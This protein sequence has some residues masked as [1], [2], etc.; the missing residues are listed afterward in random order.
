[1]YELNEK[2]RDLEPYAS[3]EGQYKIRL[4][5]NESFLRLP[6]S[7]MASALHASLG[8]ELNRYPDPAAKGLCAAFAKAYDVPV[9]NVVAGNG[10]DELISV[11][12]QSFLQKGDTYATIVPDFSMYNFYGYIAECRG[13]SISKAKDLT[14]DVDKVIETC[15]NEGVKLLIFSN[16][17]N[18]TSLGLTRGDVEKLVASVSALVVLDEAYMDFWDESMLGK[19]EAFDNLLILKTCSKAFGLAALRVGFAVGQERLVRAIQAVKSPYNVNTLSQRMAEV[20]LQNRGECGAATRRLL[21][22]R[23][24]LQRGLD[25]LAARFPEQMETLS[26]VTNFVV[27]RTPRAK[28]LFEYLLEHSIAVRYF[29]NMSALRIT[30]GATGENATVLAHIERFFETQEA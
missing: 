25:R 11:I 8:V 15:N 23:D 30:A 19:F 10:S 17:C 12:F 2:I 9:Q 1:M 16:P 27:L 26:S 5:A 21:L 20:V 7:I 29:E 14:V 18:P 13:I 28:A 3:I 6:E 24:E 22:S 4:D